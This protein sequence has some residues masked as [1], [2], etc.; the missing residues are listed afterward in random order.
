MSFL[1]H[2]L[3][4]GLDSDGQNLTVLNGII[5]A[6]NFPVTRGNAYYVDSVNGSDASSGK[7]PLLAMATI[8][9]AINKCTANQGDIIYVMP[10][11]VETIGAATII[12]CDTADVRIIGIGEG[13]RRPTLTFDT[14]NTATIPV[15]AA[16]VTFQ[17]IIFSANYADIAECFT[18]TTAKYFTCINCDFVATAANMNFV[19]IVDIGTTDNAVDGLTFI[20]CKWIE[21]DTAT[22]T[23]V[24]VDAD[25]DG[26]TFLDCYANLGVN[27]NDLPVFASVAAGKDLTNLQIGRCKVIRLN[28]ANPLFIV[29]ADTTTTNTGFIFDN[30]VVHRDT[31]SEL[32]VTAA[33]V[34]GFAGNYASGAADASGYLLP[35]VD[36]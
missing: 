26:L 21:P 2:F 8:D 19:W 5:K 14:A 27:S 7:T 28:D 25:I 22:V 6:A 1:G 30:R 33:S 17:N 11:H 20:G 16:N 35:G 10:G 31:G 23:W 32:L 9:A 13:S 34:I 4:M 29:F 12:V 36:S 24:D 3:N 18:L 15:S